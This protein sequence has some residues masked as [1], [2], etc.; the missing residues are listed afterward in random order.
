M[1]F[2][3]YSACKCSYTRCCGWPG[4]YAL[5][6]CAGCGHHPPLPPGVVAGVLPCVPVYACSYQPTCPQETGQRHR[7]KPD[8]HQ[9]PCHHSMCHRRFLSSCLFE[10]HD[11]SLPRVRAPSR[12]HST[13]R[14]QRPH[15]RSP[16][17]TQQ[18]SAADSIIS[19]TQCAS[20]HQAE[21]STLSDDS[22]WDRLSTLS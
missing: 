20:R 2:L 7:Q 19:S 10:G 6:A 15:N 5:H 1:V 4:S 14:Q 17:L 8:R 13:S 21:L 12:H 11:R 22:R 18:Q 16:L 9:L 3:G